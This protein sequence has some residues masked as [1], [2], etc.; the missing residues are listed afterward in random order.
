M[1]HTT[2]KVF[3]RVWMLLLLVL[4]VAVVAQAQQGNNRPKISD[5]ALEH[6]L[7][8]KRYLTRQLK[9]ALGEAPCDPVGR[10]L[11][12]LAPL[13]LRGSCPQCTQ[14]ETRQIQRTLSH[15]QRNYPK[16]WSKLVKQ[17]QG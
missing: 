16:E 10:R 3:S 14:E 11:K 6:A 12:T 1:V 17:Y 5:E 4:L 15:I 13:V 2:C 9:C 7:N 8:D